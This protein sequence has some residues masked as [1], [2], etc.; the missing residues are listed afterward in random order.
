M[1]ETSRDQWR[2]AKWKDT[3]ESQQYHLRCRNIVLRAE[4]RHCSSMSIQASEKETAPWS[5]F[6][7]VSCLSTLMKKHPIAI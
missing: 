4:P 6:S 1:L 7:H 2:V 3:N 5:L